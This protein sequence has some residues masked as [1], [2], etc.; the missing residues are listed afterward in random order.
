[1]PKSS[2][3]KGMKMGKTSMGI[4]PFN[5]KVKNLQKLSPIAKTCK[6]IR[7]KDKYEA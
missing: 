4:P 3:K 7:G 1:M 2:M 6:K 5:E